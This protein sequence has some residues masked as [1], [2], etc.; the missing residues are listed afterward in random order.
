[1]NIESDIIKLQISKIKT[2]EWFLGIG[3]KLND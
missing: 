2:N 1:M 3:I